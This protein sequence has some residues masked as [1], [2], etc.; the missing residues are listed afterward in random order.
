MVYNKYM[1]SHDDDNNDYHDNNT[2]NT[3]IE[4]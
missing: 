2:D 1:S 3:F 4:S